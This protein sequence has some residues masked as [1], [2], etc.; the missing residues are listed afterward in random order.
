M[1]KFN[2]RRTGNLVAHSL[3]KFAKHL[4]DLSVWMEDV[5]PQVHDVLLAD[6]G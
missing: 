3:A 4:V 5:P 1:A 2:T 6:F